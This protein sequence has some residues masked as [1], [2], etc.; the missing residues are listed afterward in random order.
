MAIEPSLT[1][2]AM[3]RR[4]R[5]RRGVAERCEAGGFGGLRV[6]RGSVQPV[7]GLDGYDELLARR[8][9]LDIA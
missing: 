7:E 3:P 4:A 1:A 2:L 8:D 5:R 9:V 6:F